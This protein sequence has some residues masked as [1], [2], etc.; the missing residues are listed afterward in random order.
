MT[1]RINENLSCNSKSIVNIIECCKCKVYIGST[2]VL[3]N[4]IYLHKN[5]I[6]LPVNRKLNTSKHLYE[7]SN[8]MRLK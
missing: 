3:N 1:F 5:D 2:Q 7:C 4:R 6:K 8:G